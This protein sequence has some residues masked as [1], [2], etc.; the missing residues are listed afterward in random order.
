MQSYD[1]LVEALD[2]LTKKGYTHDFNIADDCLI[3]HQPNLQ[4][5]PEQFH[6]VDVFRFEGMSNPDDSSIL[7]VIESTE[8]MKGTLVSAYGAYAD[9]VSNEMMEKLKIH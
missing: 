4:L 2:D 8:G 6:I 3:C 1:T 7:Y 9:E 5:R